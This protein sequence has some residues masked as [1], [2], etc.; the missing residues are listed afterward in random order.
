MKELID[1]ERET[2]AM[3]A[4]SEMVLDALRHATDALDYMTLLR[5]QSVFNFVAI[6]AVMAIA[7]LERTFMN[8]K[9]LKE[10]V[11][12]RKGETLRVCYSLFFLALCWQW[13]TKR[14]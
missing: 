5:C 2:E 9:I 13:L 6:P 11:K 3:W 4:A 12:I 7:T 14:S 8:K 10:N 1:P